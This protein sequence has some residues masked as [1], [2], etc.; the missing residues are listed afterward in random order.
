MLSPLSPPPSGAESD[1]PLAEQRGSHLLTRQ[2]QELWR[3]SRGSLVPQRLLFEVT[4]ASVVSE[5]SSKHV[6][7][8]VGGG[9]KR[10]TGKE[11]SA[12]ACEE[13]GASPQGR[14]VQSKM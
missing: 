8:R 13:V 1:S 12:P 9:Q 7:S 4:N 3:K 6:V 14:P 11:P 2:L 5:R 10:Q